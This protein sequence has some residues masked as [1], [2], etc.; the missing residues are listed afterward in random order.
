MPNETDDAGARLRALIGGSGLSLREVERRSGVDSGNLTR[1]MRGE[2]DP[3]LTTAAALLAALGLGFA[4]L[5]PPP[6]PSEGGKKKPK[7]SLAVD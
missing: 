4:D 1:L 5:D 3:R 7:K 6:A 2:T